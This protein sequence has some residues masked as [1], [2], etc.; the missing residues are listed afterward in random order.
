MFYVRYHG[1]KGRSV[2]SLNDTI[3]FADPEN[4][5]LGARIRNI[6]PI[7]A[8]LWQIFGENREKYFFI[9]ETIKRTRMPPGRVIW[10]VNGD[11]R[12]HGPTCSE[13]HET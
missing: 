11:D 3:K 12:S 9:N 1:N 7:E 4:P 10:A 6:S 13:A 5:R 8:Q 2:V